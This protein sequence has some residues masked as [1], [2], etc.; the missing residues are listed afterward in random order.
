[1]GPLAVVLFSVVERKR[2]EGVGVTLR[3]TMEFDDVS[4]GFFS[5][6]E[7]VQESE[8]VASLQLPE[9]RRTVVVGSVETV[10]GPY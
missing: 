3:I 4:D 10:G 9:V 8:V 6:Y 1:M 7:V 2:D 5:C